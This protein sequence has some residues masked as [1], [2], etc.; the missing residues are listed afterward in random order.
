MSELVCGRAFG[1]SEVKIG[2]K[3]ESFQVSQRDSE[4]T[5]AGGTNIQFAFARRGVHGYR[6]V[7]IR[8]THPNPGPQASASG[9]R[10]VT[11][12][13]KPSDRLRPTYLPRPDDSEVLE[14]SSALLKRIPLVQ[15]DH[16]V[17]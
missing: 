7:A 11:V 2:T 17:V 8:L 1:K 13:W 3:T 16:A 12:P 10:F 5:A 9:P 4:K 14:R 6:C 15:A